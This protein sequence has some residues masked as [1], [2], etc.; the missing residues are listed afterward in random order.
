MTIEQKDKAI[1]IIKG[2]IMFDKYGDSD[3]K[4]IPLQADYWSLELARKIFDSL[5]SFLKE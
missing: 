1:E 5:S 2:K 3:K 4:D